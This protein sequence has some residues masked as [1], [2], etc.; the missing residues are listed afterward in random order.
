M[1]REPITERPKGSRPNLDRGEPQTMNHEP[2][3]E[4]TTNTSKNTSKI[5]CTIV[6]LLSEIGTKW[7]F[8]GRLKTRNRARQ[9][10]RKK[11]SGH[12]KNIMNVSDFGY[13]DQIDLAPLDVD[14]APLDVDL[15]PLD[16]ALWSLN[17]NKN[18]K[19]VK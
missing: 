2:E 5:I 9:Q 19:K 13:L 6:Q 4:Q 11:Q 18:S 12:Y 7:Q 1:T 10:Y 14:L 8:L 15:A 16:F 3:Q 17:D